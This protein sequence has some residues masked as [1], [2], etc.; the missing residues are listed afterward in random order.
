MSDPPRTPDEIYRRLHAVI[1]EAFQNVEEDDIVP[2]SRL[3][4]DLGAESLDFLDLIFKIEK[5]FDFTISRGELFP[6]SILQKDLELVRNNRVTAKGI[7][8]LEE[9]MPY[10][11]LTE[12]KKNPDMAAFN[13]LFTVD[14][15]H[16]YVCH[17]LGIAM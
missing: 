2:S 7:E 8:E 3:Q 16:R 4:A 14:L 11:D 1:A 10:A 5:E 13:D 9:R 6:E 17:K 12:F 15:I